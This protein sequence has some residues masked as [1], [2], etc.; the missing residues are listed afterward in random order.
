MRYGEDKIMRLVI[1]DGTYYI[2]HNATGSV[3]KTTDI[4]EA[5]IFSSINKA[6]GVMKYAYRKTEGFYAYDMETKEIRWRNCK[7]RKRYPDEVRKMVYDNANGRCQLCGRKITYKEATMDHIIA[8]AVGGIDSV[9][10]LQCACR[11]CNH[12]KGNILPDEF[13]ERISVIFMYQMGKK[14]GDCLRWKIMN[15]MLRKMV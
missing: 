10:N 7:N 4:S 2:Y 14:Y 13:M 1:T 6:A 8:R 5:E 3:E 9:E 11:P 15:R 12:F